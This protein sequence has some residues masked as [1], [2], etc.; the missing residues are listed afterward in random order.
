MIDPPAIRIRLLT[1]V[2]GRITGIDG[3]R[4]PL[5]VEIVVQTVIRS[6]GRVVTE[7][8]V[9]AGQVDEQ[10][11]GAVTMRVQAQ[12]IKPVGTTGEVATAPLPQLARPRRVQVVVV[13]LK[14]SFTARRQDQGVPR[15][16][17]KNVVADVEIR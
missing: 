13:A 11:V 10:G 3:R 1:E 15:I 12:L 7:D 14:A 2:I 17:P 4:V 6:T 9:R 5:D 16:H 8:A